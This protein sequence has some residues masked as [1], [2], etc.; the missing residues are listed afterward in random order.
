MNLRPTHL[1]DAKVFR[2][3]AMGGTSYATELAFIFTLIFVGASE[4]LS[5]AISF[6]VGL[7]VSFVLQKIFAFSNKDSHRTALLRQSVVYLLLVA[8]NYSFTLW[9][10]W[11][12][13]DLIGLL[14][15]RSVALALTT[16]WNFFIYRNIIFKT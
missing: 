5:V 15:A 6:W 13:T 16:V 7:I 9:F 14:L 12:S 10:V 1:K 4:L 2:Y 8:V 3:L 11:V